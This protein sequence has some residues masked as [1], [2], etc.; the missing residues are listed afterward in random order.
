MYGP[1]ILA[2]FLE[3]PSKPDKY[4]HAWQYNSQ[5]DRHSKVG[6]WG[7]A[8]DLLVQSSLLR[9]HAAEGKVILG[10]NHPML[11]FENNREKAL[12]L[13]IARPA[14]P[15]TEGKESFK[16]LVDRYG[17]ILTDEVRNA[18]E[19]LPDIPVAGVGAVLIAL[20]AKATMT[21]HV[22]ALPRLYDELNSS[23]QAVHGAS[24]QA[25]AIGYVQVNAS[26]TFATSVSNRYSWDDRP[27]TISVENQPNGVLRVL[28]KLDKLPRR[29]STDRK[30]FDGIGVTVLDFENLGGPVTVVTAPPAPQLGEAFRYDTM[31]VRMANEYD[32]R[33]HSI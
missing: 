20:E 23:H 15:V 17:I 18:L 1:Q 32:S 29:A 24:N 13:V 5:S 7:V 27:P 6:C 22:A 9:K 30:G 14:G 21:A 11:D 12:D 3:T 25:I 16:Q 4:G 19:G 8:L 10:V 28:E 26:A 2:T 31:I 33:F